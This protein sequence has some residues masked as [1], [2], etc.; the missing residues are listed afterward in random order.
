MS[1]RKVTVNDELE[2]KWKEA[3]TASVK[4]AELTNTARIFSRQ[5][6]I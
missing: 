2:R 5:A 3:V 4:T 1:K 6:E